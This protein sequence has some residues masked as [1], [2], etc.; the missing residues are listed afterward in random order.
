MNLSTIVDSVQI[1]N[2]DQDSSNISASEEIIN[3]PNMN[4]TASPYIVSDADEQLLILI[5]FKQIVS[6]KSIKL[7]AFINNIKDD[8]E[9]E[10]N[11]EDIS[12]PKQVYIYKLPNADV[13]FNDI[14]SIQHDKSIK[15]S[16][17]N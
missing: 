9:N 4:R 7:Y 2:L 13:N 12:V 10:E 1:L 11:D 8:D 14:D 3:E 6:L 15:C 17:K 5:G 16:I